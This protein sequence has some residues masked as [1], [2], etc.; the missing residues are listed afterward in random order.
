[1]LNNKIQRAALCIWSLAL[2]FPGHA[3]AERY[4]STQG[5]SIDPP[6][7]WTVASKEQSQQLAEAV[8]ERLKQFDLNRIAVVMFDPANPR[9][10]INVV[11]GPGRVTVDEKSAEQYR[12]SLGNQYRQMGLEL[13]N[14]TV[15]QR[16]FGKHSALFADYLNDYAKLGGDPGKVHQWQAIFPGSGKSF[17]VTCTALADQYAAMVPIFTKTLESIDYETGMFDNMPPWMRT[18]LIGAVI[19]ALAGLILSLM[20]KKRQKPPPVYGPPPPAYGPPAPPY[21]PPPPNYGPPPP[22]DWRG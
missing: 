15:D 3:L 2:A 1:M 17:F 14:F 4:K 12:T 13:E 16:T 6:D 11:I 8:K 9:N 20:K 18:A 21:G 10:N 7:G 5:F 22:S 19:G